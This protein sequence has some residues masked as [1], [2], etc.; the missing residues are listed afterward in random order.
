MDEKRWF[1]YY[2]IMRTSDQVVVANQVFCKSRLVLR[3]LKT[4][5]GSG[6]RLRF[7]TSNLSIIHQTGN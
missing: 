4:Y 7:F 3:D 5:N 2:D 1:L 6:S